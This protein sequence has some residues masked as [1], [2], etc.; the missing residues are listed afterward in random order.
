MKYIQFGKSK[1]NYN[2]KRSTRRKTTEIVVSKTGVNVLTT[3]KKPEDEINQLLQSH[4]KW[5]FKKK[6]SI[7]EEKPLQISYENNSKLPY[8]GMNYPLLIK[9]TK[10]KKSIEFSNKKFVAKIPNPTKYKIRKL[11]LSWIENEA[12]LQLPKHVQKFTKKLGYSGNKIKSSP[13]HGKWG[14]VSK[15]GKITMNSCLIRAPETIIDYVA[16][17]ESCHLK[18]PNHSE[19][20]W[21][22]LA[23]IMPDYEERKEWL[24]VN[25]RLLT[26]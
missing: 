12:K 26:N 17:H 13:L 23:T 18:I 24:R 19:S 6:L 9:K 22:L 5:I 8:L 20:F 21:N 3:I 14:L 7:K 1:I 25:R 4:S 16:A 10:Q 11:Y 15:S 2:I